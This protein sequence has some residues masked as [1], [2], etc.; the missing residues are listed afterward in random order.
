M[1]YAISNGA[2]QAVNLIDGKAYWSQSRRNRAGQ[3]QVVLVGDTL[4]MQDEAGDLVFVRATKE[5]YSEQY[6]LPALDSKTWNLPTVAGRYVLV[7][8]D[9]QAICV[10]LPDVDP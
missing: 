10:E 1:G 5:A 2:L 3:G 8:N 4:V 7:R 6:R 9:R